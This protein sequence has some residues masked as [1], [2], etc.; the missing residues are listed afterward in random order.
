MT[1]FSNLL[2]QFSQR[3]Y[4]IVKSNCV[5]CNCSLLTTFFLEMFSHTWFHSK[6]RRTRR[7]SYC[8]RY[9][10]TL[11]VVTTSAHYISALE[12]TSV[13]HEFFHYR[14]SK[15]CQNCLITGWILLMLFNSP[16]SC[17]IIA[18]LYRNTSRKQWELKAK[19]AR[20]MTI[21]ATSVYISPCFDS[22]RGNYTGNLIMDSFGLLRV[23]TS[24]IDR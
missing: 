1:R 16:I 17:T 23:P 5:N 3:L 12:L 14:Y 22:S 15:Y 13:N 20:F 4:V 18:C 2:D 10:S 24:G 6:T 11:F 9:A 8:L 7:M 21:T 19:I